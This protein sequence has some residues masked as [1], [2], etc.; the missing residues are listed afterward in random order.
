MQVKSIRPVTLLDIRTNNPV[1]IP[2]G[3][4]FDVLDHWKGN[5]KLSFGAFTFKDVPDDQFEPISAEDLG[6]KRSITLNGE[7]YNLK[8][9]Q[10]GKGII[11]TMRTEDPF[12]VRRMMDAFVSPAIKERVLAAAMLHPEE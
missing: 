7:L 9:S 4:V 3:Y 8:V 2:A 1:S 12:N 10:N 5:Y 6:Y 11:V